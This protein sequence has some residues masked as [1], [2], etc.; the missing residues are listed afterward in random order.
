MGK[1]FEQIFLQ[2]SDTNGQV[3]EKNVNRQ[4]DQGNVNQNRNEIILYTL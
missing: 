1:E 4:R 3:H 2:I